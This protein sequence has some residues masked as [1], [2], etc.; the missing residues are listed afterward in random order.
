MSYSGE[1]AEQVVR[2]SLNGIEVAAKISG[3]AA[4]RLVI[5]I[6]SI[7][8]GQKRTKGRA[9]LTNMLRSG[10][11]LKVYAVKDTELQR[12]CREAKKYG[13]LYCVL[14]DNKADDGLTDIMVRAEDGSKIQRIF[15]RF[16]LSVADMGTVKTEL[17]PTKERQQAAQREETVTRYVAE[18]DPEDAFIERVVKAEMPEPEKVSENPNMAQ[19][20]KSGPSEPFSEITNRQRGKNA[21]RD[22][23]RDRPSVR[24]VLDEIREELK[25]ERSQPKAEPV[26]ENAL[27]VHQPV[28]RKFRWKGKGSNAR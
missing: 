6:A 5:L 27:T 18:K 14:K 21:D 16:K 25:Q 3:E 28:P 7:Y 15:E 2:M 17:L 24:K 19:T 1:A 10:K 22:P 23:A 4:T 9:R 26:R 13:V 20:M 8:K 11:E 12:F